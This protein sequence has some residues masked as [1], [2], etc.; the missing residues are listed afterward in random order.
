LACITVLLGGAEQLTYLIRE[1]M[2]TD[3]ACALAAHG[4]DAVLLSP[5]AS[6]EHANG[7]A[8]DPLMR[9]S[10]S[11]AHWTSGRGA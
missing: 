10:L 8:N 3:A 9:P 5:P 7:L 1:P 11:D 4:V 2:D 6:D